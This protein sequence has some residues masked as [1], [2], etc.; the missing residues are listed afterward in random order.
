MLSNTFRT[1]RYSEDKLFLGLGK[2]IYFCDNECYI[3]NDQAYDKLSCNKIDKKFKHLSNFA[4]L[5]Q[6]TL[7][8]TVIKCLQRFNGLC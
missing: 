5:T 2:I 1:R 7:C 4:A 8:Y 3:S 6:K